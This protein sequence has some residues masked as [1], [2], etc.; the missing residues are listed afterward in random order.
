MTLSAQYLHAAAGARR[1]KLGVF[2]G[3]PCALPAVAD[4]I[5]VT[6]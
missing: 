3:E 5:A 2:I 1:P 6:R 4:P